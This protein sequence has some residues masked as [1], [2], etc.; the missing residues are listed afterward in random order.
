MFSPALLHKSHCNR[1][2]CCL[3]PLLVSFA[4]VACSNGSIESSEREADTDIMLESLQDQAVSPAK[5]SMDGNT[6]ALYIGNSFT[7]GAG[8]STKHTGIYELTKN[9]FD[10]SRCFISLG[11]GF[12]DYDGH[13]NGT[14]YV[15]LLQE[16]VVDGSFDNAEVTHLFIIGARGECWARSTLDDDATWLLGIHDAIAEVDEIIRENFPNLRYCGYVWADAFK[17]YASASERQKTYS[18]YTI[19]ELMPNMLDGTCMHYMGWIGWDILFD[20]DCFS[21]DGYHPN[22][23]GYQ[24]L[25]HDFELAFYGSYECL[26]KTAQFTSPLYDQASKAESSASTGGSIRLI[27]T[28]AA[29]CVWFPPYYSAASLNQASMTSMLNSECLLGTASTVPIKIGGLAGER[30]NSG[31]LIMG[32]M[33]LLPQGS[34]A[35][36]TQEQKVEVALQCGNGGT[37]LYM[38]TPSKTAL[39]QDHSVAAGLDSLSNNRLVYPYGWPN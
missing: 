13:D 14:D 15:T 16:A 31:V 17:D 28:P 3:L 7:A 2:A 23:V 9:M 10:D 37:S 34:D 26:P 38:Q 24:R 30:I 33:R 27:S 25:A 35:N 20:Q 1:I 32:C 5:E 22:D 36:G 19:N 12:I 6:F 11:A 21:A 18:T 4:F 29:V 39:T 8:S